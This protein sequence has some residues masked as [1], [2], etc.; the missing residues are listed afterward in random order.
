VSVFGDAEFVKKIKDGFVCVAVNQHHHRR[1]KDLEYDLFARLVEQT[2]EKVSGYNQGLYFFTPAA[3]L[4]SFSN[5]V[6]GEHAWKL[7]RQAEQK[8]QPPATL[9]QI[10][11]GHESAG[12]L[13]TLADGSQLVLVNSKV[14]GGYEKSDNPRRLIHQES[15][16]RD[17]LY[18]SRDEISA[19]ANNQFPDS[20]KKRLPALLN[21]NTRGEPG[22]WRSSEIKKFDV[23]F[24]DGRLTGQIHLENASGDRGYRAD[25]L[26]FISTEEKTLTR[27]DIVVRGDYWGEGRFARNAPEGTFPFAVAF[28]LSDGTEPYDSPPPGVH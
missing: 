8:F 22:R 25:L 18:L 19:L 6:S 1:R 9:P 17:H 11:K 21:D 7:L 13:W 20:L 27:F 28:R 4:L 23:T 24:Q 26:G 2:G 12:P 16:G 5:T 15:L 10:L 14:L 3:E